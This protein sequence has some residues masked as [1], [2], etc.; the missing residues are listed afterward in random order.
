ME[1]KGTKFGLV[2]LV[3]Q[4][5]FI[6]LFGVFAEYDESANASKLVNQLDH[7]K[8]GQD[9]NNNEVSKYY[10]SKYKLINYEQAMI[11]HV[12]PICCEV[13][14]NELLYIC[15]RVMQ[16]MYKI[17]KTSSFETKFWSY[18]NHLTPQ[19]LWKIYTQ[20]ATQPQPTILITINPKEKIK[21]SLGH[22]LGLALPLVDCPKG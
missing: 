19:W 6:V 16:L 11:I 1:W 20:M 14:L 22:L 7:D 9:K 8:G 21:P 5:I 17:I 10:P 4:A 15:K 18:G 3:F 13:Q 12:Y 2:C